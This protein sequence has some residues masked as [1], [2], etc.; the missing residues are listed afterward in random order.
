MATILHQLLGR[1]SRS[2]GLSQR[3]PKAK[4]PEP[5]LTN[6]VEGQNQLNE[7]PSLKIKK[8]V[9]VEGLQQVSR[10]LSDTSKS[11]CS[12]LWN[13]AYEAPIDQIES[14]RSLGKRRSSAAGGA[15]REW[16]CDL[17]VWGVVVF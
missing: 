15:N 14:P 13:V 10:S 17:G 5:G 11:L 9:L 3:K 2:K 7:G 4:A 8:T 16:A 12:C 1:A 6:D